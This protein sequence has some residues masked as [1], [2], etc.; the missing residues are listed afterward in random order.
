[1]F[2]WEFEGDYYDTGTIPGYLRS[3]LAL[4][5]K[6]DDLRESMLAVI[7]EMVDASEVSG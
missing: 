3:N 7:R 5:L 4:A 6:R 1:V 2:A